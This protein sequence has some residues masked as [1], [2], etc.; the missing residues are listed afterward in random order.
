MM[1]RRALVQAMRRVTLQV[2]TID[3][4]RVGHA[5]G[6]VPVL[7]PV[8]DELALID[9]LVC[10]T[11]PDKRKVHISIDRPEGIT[12]PRPAD[13]MHPVDPIQP[14]YDSHLAPVSLP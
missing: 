9:H 3:D 7:P 2:H 1:A 5:G 11:R 13:T 12:R 10:Q 6:T 8:F 14:L 4:H